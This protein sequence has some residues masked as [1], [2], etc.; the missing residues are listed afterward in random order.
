MFL[1]ETTGQGFMANKVLSSLL[2]NW[3]IFRWFSSFFSYV[4]F[5]VIDHKIIISMA[6]L[7]IPL[8]QEGQLSV[9]LTVV[10]VYRLGGRV[11]P[12]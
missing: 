10:L 2:L 1:F 4:T 12:A 5:I 3:Q 11:T 9:L 8:I 6:T 7:P